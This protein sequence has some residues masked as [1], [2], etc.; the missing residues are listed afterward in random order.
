[1]D[2]HANCKLATQTN[3]YVER[4]SLQD[5]HGNKVKGSSRKLD[6]N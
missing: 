6:G 3:Q 5:N 1:M 4:F 2:L